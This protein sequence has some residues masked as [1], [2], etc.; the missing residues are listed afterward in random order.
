MISQNGTEGS[1][2]NTADSAIH[3]GHPPP[4]PQKKKRRE[5]DTSVYICGKILM[6]KITRNREHEMKMRALVS[7]RLKF[8]FK[9]KTL[10]G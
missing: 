3:Q 1:T 7:S 10:I 8:K 6:L 9:Y 2:I 5:V 4:P